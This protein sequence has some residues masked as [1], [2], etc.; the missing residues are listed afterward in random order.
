MIPGL[1]D[2][3]PDSNY[4]QSHIVKVNR[5]NSVSTIR[6]KSKGIVS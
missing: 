5:N 3:I 6:S 2:Q 1:Y 4:F